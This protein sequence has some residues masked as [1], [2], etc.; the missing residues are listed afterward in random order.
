MPNDSDHR[1]APLPRRRRRRAVRWGLRIALAGLLAVLVCDAVVW[2]SSVGRIAPAGKAQ[3]APQMDAAVVLGCSKALASGAPNLFFVSRIRAAAELWHAGK[4]RAF[5][6]SGDNHRQGYDE[7]GDMKEALIAAGVPEN[8]IVCDH[9]GFRTLDSVVRAKTIFGLD[10][11]LVVSQSFHL[12]RAIFLGRAHGLD[13]RGYAAAPVEGRS[14]VR[15]LIRE[16]PARVLAVLDVLLGRKP[17]FGGDPVP[18]LPEEDHG[19][20]LAADV[21]G[22]SGHLGALGF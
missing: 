19:G 7:P 22:D 12:Q 15:T 4:V 10:S 5:V 3:D 11:F 1:E 8:R 2:L 18:V 17:H 9:A 6:V 20:G 16:Q 14:A 13:V 21:D